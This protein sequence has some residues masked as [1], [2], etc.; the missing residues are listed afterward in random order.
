MF[1]TT[2]NETSRPRQVVDSYKPLVL[3]YTELIGKG[4]FRF[5]AYSPHSKLTCGF[6]ICTTICPA[7]YGI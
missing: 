4:R 1:G 7:V 2:I 5:G 3:V 6:L